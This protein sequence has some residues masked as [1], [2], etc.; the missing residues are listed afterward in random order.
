MGLSQVLGTASLLLS[1]TVSAAVSST[2]FTVS[3]QDV[4]YFLPPKPVA[5]ISDCDEL[6][7]S[8]EKGLFVPMTVVKSGGAVDAAS[9]SSAYGQD[10]VWQAGFMEGVSLIACPIIHH[11]NPC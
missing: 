4:D 3:L 7:A 2:G 8:F 11:S 5:R 6:K 9:I 10:D 1:A